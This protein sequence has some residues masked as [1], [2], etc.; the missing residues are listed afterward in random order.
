MATPPSGPPPPLSLLDSPVRRRI[1]DLLADSASR[2]GNRT[3]G[4]PAGGA[5]A[6]MTAAEVA[7]HLELHTTT[8]RF[9][10]D[11][12]E[13]GG[14]VESWFRRGGVGRPRKLYRVPTRPLP[15]PTDAAG[16][17]RALTALLTEYWTET[18]NGERLTPEQ[19]GHRWAVRRAAPEPEPG[20]QAHT[21]GAWLGK[22]GE[23]LD[24]LHGW[25]YLPEV[26]TEEGG[27][28]AELTLV[29][30]PF[31]D[32]AQ[33]SPDVVC[34]VHRGLLRGT[35]ESLGEADTE[36]SLRPF[37]EPRVCLARVRTRAEFEQPHGPLT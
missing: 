19:A 5:A 13:G 36:V 37:V 24:R 4:A 34:G 31:L 15:A 3:T 11:Q 14:L 26:R 16:P 27:R 35:L 20:P 9:H 25:G 33:E 17:L 23:T 18:E 22:V 32:L 30:C 8:A 28:T 21:P 12:L 29:D 7:A 1:V 2:T 10:L 6:G